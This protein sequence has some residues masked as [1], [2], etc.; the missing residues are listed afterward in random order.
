M[1]NFDRSLFEG[2]MNGRRSLSII[3]LLGPVRVTAFARVSGITEDRVTLSLGTANLDSVDFP[4]DGWNFSLTLAVP[5]ASIMGAKIES[6]LSG[7]R[8][9]MSL[10]IFLLANS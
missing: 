10:S 7:V 8:D 4:I 3:A 6:S 9:G 1:E 2:W 5:N